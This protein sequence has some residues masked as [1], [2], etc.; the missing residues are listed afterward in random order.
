MGVAR[1]T[2]WEA[3]F[4]GV[5]TTG[6]VVVS[7]RRLTV[8]LS[9]AFDGEA[10]C[11]DG[12]P[13]V[14]S[15]AR[16]TGVSAVEPPGFFGETARL[17]S[18]PDGSAAEA[19]RSRAS[20]VDNRAPRASGEI[21]PALCFAPPMGLT[22][23]PLPDGGPE[24]GL[25]GTGRSCKARFGETVLALDGS[26]CDSGTSGVGTLVATGG[27]FGAR[28][29]DAPGGTC[30]VDC[31]CWCPAIARPACGVVAQEARSAAMSA[32]KAKNRMEHGLW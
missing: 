21:R 18:R 31:A 1:G 5:C 26:G 4:G 29:T 16:A 30:A 22:V 27:R 20:S 24:G 23:E 25:T 28:S 12:T 2:G 15:P 7:A 32:A 3:A 8:A 10:D 6:A 13:G 19:S 11:A 14:V 17:F 9:G